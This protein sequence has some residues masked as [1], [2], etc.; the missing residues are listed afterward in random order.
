MMPWFSGATHSHNACIKKM[1]FVQRMPGFTGGI[2]RSRE[3][4]KFEAVGC[5]ARFL[6]ILGLIT[7]QVTGTVKY[8]GEGTRRGGV[9]AWR[10]HN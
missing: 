3:E 1:H 10:E 5:W 9:A 8:L 2:A 4:G 6:I 7:T